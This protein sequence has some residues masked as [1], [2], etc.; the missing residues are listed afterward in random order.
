MPNGAKTCV[1][2][3]RVLT[4]LAFWVLLLLVGGGNANPTFLTCPQQWAPPKKEKVGAGAHIISL[5]MQS[6]EKEKR[7]EKRRKSVEPA[8]VE[9]RKVQTFPDGKTLSLC[10]SSGWVKEF[11]F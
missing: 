3:V 1:Q 10:T 6:K 9:S 2:R 11:F 8:K 5:S 4:E 7:E